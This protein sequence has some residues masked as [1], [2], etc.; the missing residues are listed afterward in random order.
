MCNIILYPNEYKKTLHKGHIGSKF[1]HCREVVHLSE[2]RNDSII[3]KIVMEFLLYCLLAAASFN[4]PMQ[5]C[6]NTT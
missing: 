6:E 2:W 3:N 4:V 1:V 5:R